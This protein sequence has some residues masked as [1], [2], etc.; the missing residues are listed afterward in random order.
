MKFNIK[1]KTG[2]KKSGIE[3]INEDSYIISV[4]EPAREGKANA[5]VIKILGEYF[6]IS[7]SQIKI[8]SG[9]KSKKKIIETF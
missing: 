7:K 2:S 4:K 1:V 5:A 8:I 3:K 9:F 6:D